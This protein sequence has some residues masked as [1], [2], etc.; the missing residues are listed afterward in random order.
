MV[1]SAKTAQ[2]ATILF[3]LLGAM[4]ATIFAQPSPESTGQSQSAKPPNQDQTKP[5]QPPS[6]ANQAAS[7]AMKPVELF[8]LLDKKSFVFPDIAYNKVA[9]SP[10]Q[11]FELFVDDSVSVHSF[12]EATFGSLVGQAADSPT[13]FGEGG[14]AYAK[15][16]GS[17]LAR[18]SSANFFGTFVIASALRED[19][20]FFPEHKPTLKRSIKYSLKMLFVS[21]NDAGAE[22]ANTPLLLG[23]LLGEGLANAYWP[24]RNRTVG[25]TLFRYGLDLAERAG[26]N[27]FRDYWPVLSSKAGRAAAARKQSQ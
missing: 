2:R 13:G 19:P 18:E 24:Q 3:I 20:R 14:A 6:L 12:V 15:R 1:R 21:H 23:S 10:V 9:L 27:I 5:G 25:D 22:V 16:F 4:A 26:G 17:A 11:K 7:A 8:T